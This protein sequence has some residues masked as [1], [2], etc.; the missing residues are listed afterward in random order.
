MN[1]FLV[2]TVVD[3]SVTQG[4]RQDSLDAKTKAI[5]MLGKLIVQESRRYSKKDMLH[6][7]RRTHKDA[8][9]VDE[10]DVIDVDGV[11]FIFIDGM[12]SRIEG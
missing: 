5:T 4:Y 7:L 1:L 6:I 9:I 11:R 12:L 10:G 2:Y 3:M 8:F